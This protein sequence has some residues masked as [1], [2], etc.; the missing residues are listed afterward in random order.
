MVQVVEKI[1]YVDA[2]TDQLPRV[3]ISREKCLEILF[4]DVFSGQVEVS[5]D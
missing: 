1:V 4:T 5:D 2:T 3:E